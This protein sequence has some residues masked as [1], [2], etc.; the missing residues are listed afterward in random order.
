MN[1]KAFSGH[2]AKM[3]KIQQ[4]DIEDHG[5]TYE[6]DVKT[7]ATW[8]KLLCALIDPANALDI[9]SPPHIKHQGAT[10]R[11]RVFIQLSQIFCGRLYETYNILQF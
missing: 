8:D 5:D 11:S 2:E 3:E 9:V 4:D 6:D 10:D 1:K 7:N